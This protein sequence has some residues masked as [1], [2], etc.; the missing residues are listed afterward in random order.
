MTDWLLSLVG[1][2]EG[3]R[4]ATIFALVSAVSHAAFG[5]AAKGRA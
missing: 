3:A 1:T 4:L 2:P 5:G